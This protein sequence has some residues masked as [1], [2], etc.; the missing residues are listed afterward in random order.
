VNLRLQKAGGLFSL[1]AFEAQ[2][3][4]LIDSGDPVHELPLFAVLTS[5]SIGSIPVEQIGQL[6]EPKKLNQ[7]V[8]LLQL[9]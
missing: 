2:H 3:T 8:K 6:K 1:V 5:L 9:L 4:L 7:L